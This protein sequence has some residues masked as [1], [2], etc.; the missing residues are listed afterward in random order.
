EDATRV[1][2]RQVAAIAWRTFGQDRIEAMAA[3]RPGPGIKPPTAPFPPRPL[4]PALQTVRAA[5][6]RLEGLTLTF[7]GDGS[8]NMA[9]SYLLG[10]ATAGMHVRIGAPARY[11]PAPAIMAAAEQIAAQTGGG[12]EYPA[13]PKAA[14][15]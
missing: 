11:R 15:V 1:L 7:L 10:G 3:G 2:G 13:D 4:P 14:C 12:V 9:H 8:S 6:G 5:R